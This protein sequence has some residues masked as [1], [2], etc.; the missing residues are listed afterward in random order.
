VSQRKQRR[1]IYTS[2]GIILVNRRGQI[3]LELRASDPAIPYP[4]YWGLTGGGGLPGETPEA[5]ALREV[6][7]ETGWRVPSMTF[8]RIYRF[9]GTPPGPRYEV[10]IFHAPAPNGDLRPGEGA[11]LRFFPPEELASLDLAY[12]HA[13]VLADFVA[14]SDYRAYLADGRDA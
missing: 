11:A 12:N 6:E 13:Q 14:S 1:H 4:G 9:S 10:H 3:L 7:E 2:A 5:T 8:F